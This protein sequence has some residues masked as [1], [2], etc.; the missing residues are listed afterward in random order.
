MMLT[1][2]HAE[3]AFLFGIGVFLFRS[4]RYERNRTFNEVHQSTLSG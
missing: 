1:I 4:V 3:Q 2:L